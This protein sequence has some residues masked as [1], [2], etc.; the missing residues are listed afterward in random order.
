MISDARNEIMDQMSTAD[1]DDVAVRILSKASNSFLDKALEMRLKTIEAK[2]LIN[3]LARAERLGYEP[4]DVQDDGDLPATSPFPAAD[5]TMQ[6][7]DAL[8]RNVAHSQPDSPAPAPGLPPHCSICFRRFFVAS[9]H[10]YHM[11]HRVC[12]RPAPANTGFKYSCQHC[13]QGFTTVA[14]LN[15][16]SASQHGPTLILELID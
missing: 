16:V 13:G 1:L 9:A 14:G 12:T 5:T 3:A 11:K 6:H 8:P 4:S 7:S 10:A 2:H 15:Y